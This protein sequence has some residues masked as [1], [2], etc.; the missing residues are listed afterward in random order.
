MDAFKN[1]VIENET[2]I[3]R[4]LD[5]VNHSWSLDVSD[6]II[7]V[8]YVGY[9]GESE[10]P[11][12]ILVSKDAEIYSINTAFVSGTRLFWT[13]DNL[14]NVSF[15]EKKEE[16]LQLIMLMI[17]NKKLPLLLQTCGF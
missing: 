10:N 4:P 3:F 11:V 15:E 5:F 14:S 8:T 2:I 16:K 9:I 6:I 1:I 12:I 7:I 13:T 17:E